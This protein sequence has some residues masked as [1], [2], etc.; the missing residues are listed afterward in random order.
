MNISSIQLNEKLKRRE[1]GEEQ[2]LLLDVRNKTEQDICTIPGTDILIPVKE[3]NFEIQKLNDWKDKEIVV[4]CKS[5]IR[6]K[7][8]EGI[9]KEYGFEKVTHLSKGILEYIETVDSEMA[10]Y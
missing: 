6:S 4:Y 8:A 7:T 2:F 10:W 5:G 9:L 3:L 1:K